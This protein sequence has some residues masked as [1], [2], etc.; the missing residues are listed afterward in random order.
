MTIREKIDQLFHE[1]PPEPIVEYGPFDAI[2]PTIGV[3]H[4]AWFCNWC[5]LPSDHLDTL[6]DASTG[7][8]DHARWHGDVELG[9]VEVHL[10]P[11]EKS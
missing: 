2:W 3:D 8:Q 4:Y 11:D 6:P 9:I 7:A 1:K 5:G 10:D